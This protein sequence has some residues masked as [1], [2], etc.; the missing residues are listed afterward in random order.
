M[1]LWCSQEPQLF[2]TKKLPPSFHRPS[3]WSNKD[4]KP[5][6][7]LITPSAPWTNHN[8]STVLQNL[9]PSQLMR[10]E[11]LPLKFHQHTYW[12]LLTVLLLRHLEK[13]LVM[14]HSNQSEERQETNKKTS[15]TTTTS[16]SQSWSEEDQ[17]M[18]L[19]FQRETHTPQM[20]QLPSHQ[21]LIKDSHMMT[22]IK[23][24]DKKN[25]IS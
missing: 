15:L 7:T 21:L 11:P 25:I 20:D 3:Q 5:N 16:P 9:S 19:Q 14:T 1:Q 22:E 2:K 8:H 4:L 23:I 6:S 13:S 18:F 12:T 24:R 17:L 10:R